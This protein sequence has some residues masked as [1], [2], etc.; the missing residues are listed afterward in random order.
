M[1]KA[2]TS[3]RLLLMVAGLGALAHAPLLL[4]LGVRLWSEEHYQ[5]VPI[6]LAAAIALGYSRWADAGRELGPQTGWSWGWLLLTPSLLLTTLAYRG[7]SHWLGAVSFVVF[8][9][10]SV[11]WCGGL[12]LLRQ[13]G[14]ALVLL[15]MCI[16]LPLQQDVAL[17]TTLQK[18]AA[19]F[20]SGG[21]DLAGLRHRLMGVAI[22][23]PAK[24]YFVE[25]ACSG[26]NSLFSSLAF[27][28]FYL[29]Y[30]RHHWLRFAASFSQ[31]I[32]WVVLVNALRVF[33]VVYSDQHWG[34]D[35]GEGWVH[36][37]LG[38][39]GF[40]LILLLS[41]SGDYLL[42]ALIPKFVYRLGEHSR[43]ANEPAPT[44]WSWMTPAWVALALVFAAGSGVLL[45]TGGNQEQ[46]GGASAEEMFRG[47]QRESLP[48]EIGLWSVRSFD[49]L[50]RESGDLRGAASKLWL[51][52]RGGV[53]V[54]FS[55]DG[56]FP[57]WHDL[58]YCYSALDWKLVN[59][60]NLRLPRDAAASEQQPCTQLEFFTK[61]DQRALI[62]FT[63]YDANNVPV[64]PLDPS[65]HALRRLWDRLASANFFDA[66]AQG[67][68]K[69]PVIQ[70]QMQVVSDEPLAEFERTEL[71][72]L[73]A[74]LRDMVRSAARGDAS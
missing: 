45:R 42:L 23:T 55:M 30:R 56:P 58:A 47:V 69:P 16:P 41:L 63:C 8:L 64:E 53:E 59:A 36:Q 20:A 5:H 25:E 68:V 48:E 4:G 49:V 14:G 22:Q 12:P 7:E 33:L 71:E 62:Y 9:L 67:E 46:A 27:V 10:A 50:R 40:A 44:A 70:A 32:V 3:E 74:K 1:N 72:E 39:G 21:L 18:F 37:L 11:L 2:I 43:P 13:M 17:V 34:V 51:L 54:R 29:L 15:A 28:A 31:V 19:D 6:V 35:L 65:G 38:A 26:V 52:T 60:Q 57:R 73:F 66:G 61:D 24:T